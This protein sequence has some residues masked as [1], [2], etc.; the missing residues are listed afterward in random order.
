MK[1]MHGW[2]DTERLIIAGI[3]LLVVFA[4]VI[5]V[6]LDHD[7]FGSELENRL[8]FKFTKKGYW[9]VALID[10]YDELWRGSAEVIFELL[11]GR[12]DDGGGGEGLRIEQSCHLQLFLW[13]S[14]VI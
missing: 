11:R 14:L 6:E 5:E 1:C 3:V 4:Q 10:Q 7:S 8:P 12:R 9:A 13:R 2:M